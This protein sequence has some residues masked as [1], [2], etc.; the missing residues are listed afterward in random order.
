MPDFS[1]L[2]S[3]IGNGISN[4]V[5]TAEQRLMPTPE[6]ME[7]LLS[8]DDIAAARRQ[9]LMHLGISLLGDQ[10]QH[11]GEALAHGLN[12]AQQSYGGD[13]TQT[14]QQQMVGQ[15][16]RQRMNIIKARQQ[17]A[18]QFPPQP[19]EAPA[20]TIDRMKGM[21]A[22]YLNAGDLESAGKLGEVLKSI[23]KDPTPSL[24]HV[25]TG[26][27]IL[28]VDPHSGAVITRYP[29]S[30]APKSGDEVSAEQRFNAQNLNSILDDYRADSQD[31]RK[32]MSG[33]ESIKGAMAHPNM[34]QP[35]AVL[36]SYARVVNPGAVVR[37]GTMAVLQEM[38]SYDQK[39][40]RWLD[41]AQKGQWP[42][43]MLGAIKNTVDGIMKEHYQDYLGGAR[44]RALMRGKQENIDITPYLDNFDF[45]PDA[46]SSAPATTGDASKVRSLLGR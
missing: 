19:N 2:L 42:P 45:S 31:F 28:G 15:E 4:G 26:K 34:A 13:L 44:K 7:G 10:S 9:G 8:P 41:M 12:A 27:E 24:Q 18:Q 39:V 36:D 35:F 20:Q 33:Y 5:N 46:A 38:G 37:Q 21:F 30:A 23:G 43:D 32:A 25:D 17:I 11:F 40:R 6:G 16:M 1:G 14:A 3:R 22:A 29:K